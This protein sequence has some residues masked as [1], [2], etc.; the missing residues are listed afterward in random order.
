[1][2]TKIWN[3]AFMRQFREVEHLLLRM[4][5]HPDHQDRGSMQGVAT[6]EFL[7]WLQEKWLK[8]ELTLNQE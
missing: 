7:T 5:M 4:D 2:K 8:G 1:M 6:D 3:I